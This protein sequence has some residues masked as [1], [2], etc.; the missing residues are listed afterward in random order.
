MANVSG[1]KY[2][3][4]TREERNSF[5]F[6]QGMVQY[7]SLEPS[8]EYLSEF[9]NIENGYEVL[10]LLL[11]PGLD[12]E[13]VRL[14][15]E[16]RSIDPMVLDHMEELLRI[17]CNLFSAMCRYTFLKPSHDIMRLYRKDRMLSWENL[18]DGMV[19]AFFSTSQKP[20]ISPFFTRKKYRI[21]LEE[22]FASE[23]IVHIKVNDILGWRHLY[24][25]EEEV[26]FPPFLKVRCADLELTDEEKALRDCHNHEPVKKCCI[27]ID[28]IAL[29]EKYNDEKQKTLYNWILELSHIENAKLVWSK[30]HS[31]TDLLLEEAQD[32]IRWKEWIGSYVKAEYGRIF[33]EMR[34]VAQ[35]TRK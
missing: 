23:E 7:V 4:L 17:Y 6:Y 31:N 24:A 16:Q 11:F 19:N 33:R 27:N 5:L 15:I 12:S 34:D 22:V 9:Y 8:Q 20:R 29:D 10:D 32:Y 25:S 18:K 13:N 35:V 21:L 2:M 14:W 30:I 28:G 1:R 3:N 26:L